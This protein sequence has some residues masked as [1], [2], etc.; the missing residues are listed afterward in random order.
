MTF[1][2]IKRRYDRFA[3]GAIAS[4]SEL[5]RRDVR[6][7]DEWFYRERGWTWLAFIFGA[8]TLAAAVAAQ[9]PWNM[10]FLEAAILF[11]LFAFIFVWTGL[12]AWFGHRR[13]RGRTLRFAVITMSIAIFAAFATA[14]IVDMVNGRPPFAFMFDSARVRHIF[15]ALVVFAFAYTMLVALIANLRNREYAAL[16]KHLEADARQHAL[17]RQ[18]AESQ[19]RLL[20][21]QIEPHFLFNT[22]GSA[23]QLAEKGAPDAAR[24]IAD[25]IRFLRAATPSLRE[26]VTTLRQEAS[27]IG[28]YLAIMRTRLGPRLHYRIEMPSALDDAQVPPGML[29]TLVENAIKHGIE[30]SQGGG[31]IAVVAEREHIGTDARLVISVVD[32][33]V[34]LKGGVPGLGI[35]LA[36][37]RERLALLYGKRAS[38]ELAEASPHGF[39]ARLYVPLDNIVSTT[40]IATE[41]A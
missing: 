7:F 38:L 41:S 23:Q 37:V 28:A 36:N 12:T 39:C 20:Q 10:S 11:N 8:T 29:I 34:G 24:L 5:E 25:L 1:E 35:G 3:E 9:L 31:E 26:D 13:F 33:G 32:S 2:F 16:A 4:L 40:V 30:P 17:S 27:M 21:L 18:L 19:L 6:A 15:T 22:L 14:A